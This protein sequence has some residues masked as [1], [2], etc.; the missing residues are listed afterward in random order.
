[1][2]P[3]WGQQYRI[4]SPKIYTVPHV[5]RRLISQCH[6]LW[7]H[8]PRK[9]NHYLDKW[10]LLNL[11]LMA[12]V[13]IKQPGARFRLGVRVWHS[14]GVL[15]PQIKHPSLSEQHRTS[16][17]FQTKLNSNQWNQQEQGKKISKERCLDGG[18]FAHRE[19]CERNRHGNNNSCI[20]HNVMTQFGATSLFSVH[21]CSVK[22]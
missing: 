19:S 4:Q 16:T 11:C 5:A 1:M 14:K 2:E 18:L 10:N 12:L 13:P 17:Y 22:M 8:I 21:C 7:G 9:I 15:T 6:Q 3:S 20:I